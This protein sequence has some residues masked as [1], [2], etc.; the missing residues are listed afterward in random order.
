[1]KPRT[2]RANPTKAEHLLWQMLRQRQVDGRKFRRQQL[3]GRYIVDFVCLEF[4][5]VVEV[6]GGQHADSQSDVSRD[7]WLKSEGYRVLRLWNNDVLQ[8]LEGC[9]EAIRLALAPL[10]PP[11]LPPSRGEE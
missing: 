6:D 11:N 2:L 1:M 3:I 9:V 4:R 10:P 7:A 5:L 8:N